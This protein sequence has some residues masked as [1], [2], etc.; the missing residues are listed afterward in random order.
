MGDLR[1]SQ[2]KQAGVLHRSPPRRQRF[3]KLHS[4]LTLHHVLL[5]A[6]ELCNRCLARNQSC[7]RAWELLGAASERSGGPAAEATRHFERAW[8]LGG[9][10]DPRVGYRLGLC[11]LKA[12]RPVDAAATACAVLSMHPAYPRVR[13]EVLEKARAAI[14][15]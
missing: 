5:A 4:E 11:Y 1:R 7:V 12:C 10:C 8:E 14:R 15:A 2:R 13:K 9:S 6:Q 3:G